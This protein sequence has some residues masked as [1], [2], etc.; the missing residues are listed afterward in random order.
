MN[1]SA[2]KQR[3]EKYQID[4]VSITDD[5]IR[6]Q[7]KDPSISSE[8]IIEDLHHMCDMGKHLCTYLTKHYHKILD[9]LHLCL[10]KDGI[11]E[12]MQR[13]IIEQELSVAKRIDIINRA[14]FILLLF[15]TVFYFAFRNIRVPK[16]SVS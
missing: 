6:N 9:D 10:Q 2:V 1:E 5:D 12:E 7:F 14:P 3:K 11:S 16:K 15:A 4:G 8:T 13:Y